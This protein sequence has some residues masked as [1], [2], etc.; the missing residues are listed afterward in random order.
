MESERS[1]KTLSEERLQSSRAE[2][3]AA[4]PRATLESLLE[5][6]D[7][8]KHLRIILKCDAQGTLEALSTALYQI[9][10]KKVDL[11]IIHSGVGPI[12][13]NDIL[14]ASASNTVVVGF[15]IK[16]E[17]NAVNAAKREG[18]QVKLYSIIYELI[19]QI[20]ESMAG[21]LDPE[22]RETVIGHAE[23]KQ[24][25]KLS[26]GIVAGCL[27][28]DGRIGRTSRARVLRRRQPV[29]DGGLSTLRRFQD[30]VK[31][32]RVGLECGIKLGDFNEY[33]VGDIIEC[34][35]LEQVAQK[36]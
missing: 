17:A 4:P 19:D 22:H 35:N 16:V 21:L 1:A 10:S 25:F 3:L 31:E 2:K 34:Y 18:V 6:A 33:Q 12:S 23:V 26:R 29:Y 28:T 7:G 8:K 13:E 5:A 24:V 36:L 9:E 32:V 15:N 30:D 14:L 11:D 20:K 27:V